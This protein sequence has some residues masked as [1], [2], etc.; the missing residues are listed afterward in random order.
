MHGKFRFKV[1]KLLAVPIPIIFGNRKIMAW[2]G[3]SDRTWFTNILWEILTSNSENVEKIARIY[4]N[5]SMTNSVGK[6][7]YVY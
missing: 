5:A 3:E 2:H 6:F 7:T 1:R 4:P